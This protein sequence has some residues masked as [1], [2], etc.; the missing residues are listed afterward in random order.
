MNANF[1]NSSGLYSGYLEGMLSHKYSIATVRTA[2][3]GEVQSW[4]T[5]GNGGF[6]EQLKCAGKRPGRGRR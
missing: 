4:M 2:G 6:V 5:V 3:S 1:M